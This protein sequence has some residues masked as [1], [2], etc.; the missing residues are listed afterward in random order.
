M[1][2]V[3]SIIKMVVCM[4]ESGGKIKWK[5]LENYIINLVS[6]H[7][8]EIGEMINLWAKVYFLMKSLMS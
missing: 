3:N 7:T 8:R 2:M 1:V 4:M 5:V 6:L